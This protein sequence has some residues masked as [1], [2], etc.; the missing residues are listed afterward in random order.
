MTKRI[1]PPT[2]PP[3]PPPRSRRRIHPPPWARASPPTHALSFPSSPLLPHS[4]PIA[5]QY[6]SSW[7]SS[8]P[9]SASLSCSA[10]RAPSHASLRT[11]P[12]PDQCISLGASRVWLQISVPLEFLGV[13]SLNFVLYAFF[14]YLV[15]F[16]Q[17]RYGM[18]LLHALIS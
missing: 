10:T 15:L 12:W 16:C 5:S 18:R 9:S 6:L 7:P 11:I 1:P 14:Y 17:K 8:S 3:P 2:P 13:R 4:L